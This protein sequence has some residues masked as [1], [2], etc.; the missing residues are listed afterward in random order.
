ME[1][2][3]HVINMYRLVTGSRVYVP[4]TRAETE[5]TTI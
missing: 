1:A 3:Y 4:L 2:A 5:S